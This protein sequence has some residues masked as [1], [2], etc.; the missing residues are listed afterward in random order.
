MNYEL[1]CNSVRGAS[2][3]RKGTPCEDFGIKLDCGG[4]KIF[5]VAD[6]HGDSNCLRSNIGSR[7]VCEIAAEE[8]QT[9]ALT[10]AEQGWEDRLF[11]KAEARQLVDRLVISIVGKW[12]NA[13]CDEL[14]RNPLTEEEIKKAPVLAREYV[15]GIRTERMYG[16]TLIAGLQTKKYLLLLQ[17][18]DGRCVVFDCSGNVSQPIP[19][20]DRCFGTA[21]TSLCDGDAAQSCRYHIIDL[22]EN[23]VIACVAGTDGVEDSFPTSME[24]TH[25]FY[26]DLLRYACENGVPALET[27][28]AD[29][30]NEL[31]ENGSADDV[32]VSGIVDVERVRP[33]LEAFAEKN[34]IV[35][36]EDEVTILSSKVK[37]IEEGGKFRYLEKKYTEATAAFEKAESVFRCLAED[38]DA[39]A[40]TIAAHEQAASDGEDESDL[41]AEIAKKLVLP[42]DALAL[43]KEDYL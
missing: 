40:E 4:I 3:I 29:Q 33:F 26:R 13:V 39:L 25:T 14:D 2:H 18:G 21:T 17:Q 28:L 37:S 10:L 23:P 19:W 34:R 22:A 38:C 27:L 7:Y 1:F 35:E 30:L 11:D 12:A 9:F 41:M 36:L 16:T 42:K 32:T 8:L 6:G 5:A 31:S 43:V 24:K 20:D 15:K